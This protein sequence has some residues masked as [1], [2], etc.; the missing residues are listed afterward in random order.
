[1]LIFGVPNDQAE[2]LLSG[3]VVV[4]CSAVNEVLRM[5]VIG[6]PVCVEVLLTMLV[7]AVSDDEAVALLF[8]TNGADEATVVL[9]ST[10]MAVDVTL[11]D[12][13]TVVI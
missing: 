10:P 11:E 9:A 7:L 13:F 6:D 1:M 8:I 4:F 5:L 12:L 2:P 3:D